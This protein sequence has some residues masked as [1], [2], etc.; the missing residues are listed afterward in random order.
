MSAFKPSNKNQWQDDFALLLERFKTFDEQ[1]DLSV[2]DSQKTLIHQENKLRLF[3]YSA[4]QV[5][6]KKT[7]VLIVYALVNRPYIT[8]LDQDRSLV[9]RLLEMGYP[10]Y[11]LDWGYPDS[12]DSLTDLND[13]I[14]GQLYRCV[15]QVKR[16]NQIK[17]IDLLGICQ[18]GVFSLCYSA[19]HRSDIRKL[20]TLVTPVDFH[21]KDNPLSLWT[22]HIEPT[23]LINTTGNIAGD[24]VSLL[25]KTLKPYQ[26]N[27]DNYRQ[28][29]HLNKNKR[30]LEHFLRMEKWLRDNPDL[31]GQAAVEF[32]HSFYQQNKL[33]KGQLS[34]ADQAVTLA[35]IQ[36]PV[37]NLYAKLD[38][39]VPPSSS[40]ALAQHINPELYQEHALEGGHIGAFTSLKTQ[41]KLTSLLVNWLS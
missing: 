10:V 38:H 37:L 13:Y 26:L 28:I 18:G 12:S 20:V 24:T 31:A 32:M 3:R 22:Q 5:K 9:L 29:E 21:T 17:K 16:L 40:Q 14:N 39:I 8:D 11:L 41:K 34:L 36:C 35:N 23:A 19:L 33:H 2:G 6:Q 15:Q 7:P 27:R 25:F 30:A 4:R 1:P